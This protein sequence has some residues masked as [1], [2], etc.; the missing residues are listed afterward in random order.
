MERGGRWWIYSLIMKRLT[1]FLL[2]LV[3]CGTTTASLG[4]TTPSAVDGTECACVQRGDVQP[5]RLNQGI[6]ESWRDPLGS[7]AL[8]REGVINGDITTSDQPD[9][10]GR[11][12]DYYAVTLEA[13]DWVRFW[14]T[15]SRLDMMLAVRAPDDF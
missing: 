13:G 12:G 4:P 11:L 14:S 1:C 3:G 15:G 10:R 5:P 9:G 2:V 7:P 6:P 8:L